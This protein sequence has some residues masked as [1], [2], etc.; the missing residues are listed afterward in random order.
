MLRSSDSC[1]IHIIY[2]GYHQVST[3][4]E[5]VLDA[6]FQFYLKQKLCQ[7]FISIY[8]TILTELLGLFS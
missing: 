4:V 5:L 2:Y 8:V 1:H 3:K 7:F 6:A